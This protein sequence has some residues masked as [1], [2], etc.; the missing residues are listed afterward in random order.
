MSGTVGER[1]EQEAVDKYLIDNGHDPRKIRAGSH[2]RNSDEYRLLTEAQ[3]C[4]YGAIAEVEIRGG[5]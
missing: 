1:L 4:A 5:S 2:V 3:R